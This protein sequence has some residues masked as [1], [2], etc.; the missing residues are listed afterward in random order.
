MAPARSEPPGRNYNL[1][2]CLIISLI[3]SFFG[4]LAVSGLIIPV[5][6]YLWDLLPKG[7]LGVP[8]QLSSVVCSGA[9]WLVVLFIPAIW[10]FRSL[11]NLIKRYKN[12]RQRAD[13]DDYLAGLKKKRNP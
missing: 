8:T 11:S 5:S 1:L 9:F 2:S 12:R 7:D 4:A 13:F 3:G 10:G 6:L